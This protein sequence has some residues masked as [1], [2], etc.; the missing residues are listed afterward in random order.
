M[1]GVLGVLVLVF[2]RWM[3]F[4]FGVTA[5]LIQPAQRLRRMRQMFAKDGGILLED[6]DHFTRQD[7]AIPRNKAPRKSAKAR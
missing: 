5:K 3:V 1:L 4:I 7:A 6:Y 2:H